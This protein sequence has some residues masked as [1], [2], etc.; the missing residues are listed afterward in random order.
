MG[1]EAQQ[2]PV[3]HL[4]DPRLVPPV[5]SWNLV[6]LS[7]TSHARSRVPNSARSMSSIYSRRQASIAGLAPQSRRQPTMS[8]AGLRTSAITTAQQRFASAGAPRSIP[9]SALPQLHE[10]NVGFGTS[11]SDSLSVQPPQLQQPLSNNLFTVPTQMPTLPQ[12]AWFPQT[13]QP[14]PAYTPVQFAPPV[15]QQRPSMR[16]VWTFVAVAPLCIYATLPPTH[17]GARVEAGA[18]QQRVACTRTAA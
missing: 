16:S 1:E 10:T 9:Q 14:L 15:V 12:D 13:Q 6:P 18:D 17:M 8:E 3:M 7:V 5:N 4:P 11:F 2:A